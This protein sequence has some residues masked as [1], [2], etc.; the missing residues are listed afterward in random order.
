VETALR[1]QPALAFEPAEGLVEVEVCALSGLLPGPDC[2]HRITEK[3]LPGTEPTTSCT[4]HQRI[5]L[6]RATGLRATEDTPP[7]R[8]VERLYTFLPPE[9][10][11]WAREQG[12]P[13]PPPLLAAHTDSDV[14]TGDQE[15]RGLRLNQPDEGAVYR[16]DPGLAREAQR[17]QVSALP[18]SGAPLAEVTLE[19]DGQVLARFN[20]PPFETYWPLETG[21]HVFV[22]WGMDH[23]GNE[24]ISEQVRVQVR[25]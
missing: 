18:A 16:L 8:V 12:L 24:F 23:N 5:A 6:D 17:I 21:S 2:P 11:Q 10:Q 13:E 3:F 9:A 4:M 15:N 7:E 1:G 19:V 25:E 14:P 20:S 22:A